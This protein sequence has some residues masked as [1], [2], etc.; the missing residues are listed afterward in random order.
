MKH[1]IHLDPRGPG[2]WVRLGKMSYDMGNGDDAL[3]YI[4][5]ALE[6]EP[7]RKDGMA[8]EALIYAET[9][10]FDLAKESATRALSKHPDDIDALY[11]LGIVEKAAGNVPAAMG[12]WQTAITRGRWGR[13]HGAR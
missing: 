1:A 7:F 8:A 3:I 10:R 6:L 9:G 4:K 12:Y 2:L 13:S 5:T 11:A